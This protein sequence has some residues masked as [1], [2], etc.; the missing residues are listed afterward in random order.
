MTPAVA[1]AAPGDRDPAFGV[2]GISA[3][4]GGQIYSAAETPDGGTVYLSNSGDPGLSP[5]E[6]RKVTASGAPDE[7]FGTAGT[8]DLPDALSAVAVA[9]SPS[10]RIL[11][12]GTVGQ[13]AAVARLL[14]DGSVD[15]T[16][17]SAG[18]ATVELPG[19]RTSTSRILAE[20]S[21][22][23]VVGITA[24]DADG[25][26]YVPSAGVLRLTE[27]GSPD[28]AFGTGGF[29]AF[30]PGS[31]NALARDGAGRYLLGNTY[32][33]TGHPT[34]ARFGTGGE[35]DPSFGSGGVANLPL[36]MYGIFSGAVSAIAVDATD[37]PVVFHGGRDL[38]STKG[39][40]YSTLTRLDAGGSVDAA[41]DASRIFAGSREQYRAFGASSLVIDG[42]GRVVLAGAW[43]STRY[44][45]SA[46]DPAVARLLPNGA[47]DASFGDEGLAIVPALELGAEVGYMN[48]L[49][50][51]TDGEIVAFG[52]GGA[53]D[54]RKPRAPTFVRLLTGPGKADADADAIPDRR[55][56]CPLTDGRGRNGGCPLQQRRVKIVGRSN[57]GFFTGVVVGAPGCASKVPVKLMRMVPGRDEVVGRGRTVSGRW[58]IAGDFPIGF[59]YAV[60]PRVRNNDVGICV[61]ARSRTAR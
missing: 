18:I 21:G 45:G 61:R 52:S 2:R 58:N 42:D 3:P 6:L 49:Y 29:S 40:G 50:L 47:P 31:A 24:R 55:D 57:N 13:D 19:K 37:R 12:D 48:G 46:S 16:F 44:T 5:L 33:V 39:G 20:P 59:Y 27:Q 36:P 11:V 34:V 9:V 7:T 14:G 53:R 60:T 28:S 17:G 10:G 56:Q 1:I 26:S 51:G 4:P 35:L 8:G 38:A 23:A 41:F 15:A 32:E 54:Y 22:G 43:Q 30:V 25:S